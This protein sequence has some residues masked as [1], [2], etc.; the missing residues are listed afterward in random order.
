M[1]NKKHLKVIRA[2]SISLMLPFI[3]CACTPQSTSTGQSSA[4]PTQTASSVDGITQTEL[5]SID[6]SV[7]AMSGDASGISAGTIIE[8]SDSGIDITGSGAQASDSTVTISSQGSYLI[9]G[10]LSDGQIIIDTVD[11]EEITLY[12][13]GVDVYCS[14]SSPLLIYTASKKVVLY[15]VKYSL[16]G[17]TQGNGLTGGLP[18][19]RFSM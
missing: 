13:N 18:P 1:K 12:L 9:S 19:V 11:S 14:Y 16:Q 2:I 5:P 4:S 10:T 3:L 7:S 8:L 6:F 17:T 15:T